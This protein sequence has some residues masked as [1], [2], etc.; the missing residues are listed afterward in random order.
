MVPR[1]LVSLIA[2]ACVCLTGGCPPPQ[3]KQVA[4]RVFD[5]AT[6]KPVPFSVYL[7]D[8][9]KAEVGAKLVT[10]ALADKVLQAGQNVVVVN[11]LDRMAGAG[12]LDDKQKVDLLAVEDGVIGALTAGGLVCH[13]KTG[14]RTFKAVK[15]AWDRS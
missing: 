12:N 3:P 9:F 15:G 8:T 4:A 5:R 7:Y 13:E 11:D 2:A 6:L 14:I 1:L 10:R